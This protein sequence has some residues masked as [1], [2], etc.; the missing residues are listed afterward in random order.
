MAAMAGGLEHVLGGLVAFGLPSHCVVCKTPLEWPLE[1]PI[2]RSCWHSL[3]LIR[4]PYCSRCGLPYGHSVAAGLCGSCLKGRRFRRARAVGTYEESLKETLHALKF[5]GRPRLAS[6][7]GRLA[8]S[9]WIRTGDL[10][11]GEAIVPVPLHWRRRRERGFNQAELLGKVIARAADRPCL[12]A[13]AKIAPRPP[14]AGLSA[15]ARL[16]NAAGVYRARLPARLMGKRL[17][18]VDDVFTTGATVEACTRALL[19]A[20][21]RSV[22]VLTLARVL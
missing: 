13:L 10:D 7:L 20:G 4:P 6:A 2:C 22:D 15:A 21:A 16:E 14:Q 18:L 17:L 5:G 9:N 1:R 11:V 12:R 8:F 3:P 19:R